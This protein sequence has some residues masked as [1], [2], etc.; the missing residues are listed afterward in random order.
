MTSKPTDDYDYLFKIVVVGDSGVGKS[1]I[2]SRYIK[3]EFDLESKTTLGVEFAA[4]TIEVEG[5]SIKTQIWDTAGQERF[6]AIATTY[7]KGAV[8]ALLCYDITRES[9][10]ENLEKWLKEIRD[11]TEPHTCLLLIGNKCDLSHLRAIKQDE[12][13]SFAEKHNMAYLE[14]SALDSTNI[15]LAFESLTKEIYNLLNADAEKRKMSNIKIGNADTI[16]LDDKESEKQ[17]KDATNCR[18]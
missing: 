18:C 10:F 2:L 6:R 3:N 7:Y 9:T 11:Y 17:T 14:T 15:E 5:K 1:N 12:A 8:G 16:R 13:A 4:K